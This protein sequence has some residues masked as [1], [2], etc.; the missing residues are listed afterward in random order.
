MR[1]YWT[2]WW[3]S[4]NADFRD[5]I[6]HMIRFYAPYEQ[7]LAVYEKLKEIQQKPGKSVREYIRE[8]T[9]YVSRHVPGGFEG[10]EIKQLFLQG[11]SE[12]LRQGLGHVFDL[13]VRDIMTKATQYE[14]QNP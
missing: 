7:G 5:G 9:V 11:L 8:F 14:M 4:E 2:A 13:D 3:K 1:E 10:I 6:E 12:H